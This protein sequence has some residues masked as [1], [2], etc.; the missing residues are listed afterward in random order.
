VIYDKKR[1]QYAEWF[2]LLN[3]VVVVVC[4]TAIVIVLVLGIEYG[5]CV[6]NW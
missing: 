3:E 2:R 6:G 1:R 4:T 5:L